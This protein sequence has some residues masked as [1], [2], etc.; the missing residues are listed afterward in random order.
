MSR[1]ASSIRLD[2]IA[3]HFSPSF[4]KNEDFAW[5]FPNGSKKTGKTRASGRAPSEFFIMYFLKAIPKALFPQAPSNF[6]LFASQRS[7]SLLLCLNIKGFTFYAPIS[8]E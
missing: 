5:I 8:L 1:Q 2:E 7:Q 6:F 4:N 3:S